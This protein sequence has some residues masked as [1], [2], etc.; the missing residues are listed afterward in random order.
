MIDTGFANQQKATLHVVLKYGEHIAPPPG[1]IL[2]HAQVLKE[3]GA[4]WLGKW[5]RPM[6]QPFIRTMRCQ[7]SD[8]S[9]TYVFLIKSFSSSYIVHACTIAE[10][11]RQVTDKT[12]IPA[13]YREKL[14]SIKTW[15][16][17]TEII[18]INPAILDELIGYSSRM[19]IN[20][21]ISKSMSGALYVELRPKIQLSDFIVPTPFSKC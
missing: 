17:L 19:P 4:V 9:P 20:R 16:K 14:S 6:G 7:I 1:T 2:L 15:L 8:A 21:T 18:E 10:I 12:M 5:G 11:A 13:Y 3:H